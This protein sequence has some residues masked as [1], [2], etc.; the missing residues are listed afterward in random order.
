MPMTTGLFNTLLIVLIIN[1]LLLGIDQ[2][3]NLVN[4]YK[5]QV[6]LRPDRLTKKYVDMLELQVA[7]DAQRRAEQ[8]PRSKVVPLWQHNHGGDDGH[9]HA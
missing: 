8:K 9:G 4:R 7:M 2:A 5:M 6:G 3:W 1:L